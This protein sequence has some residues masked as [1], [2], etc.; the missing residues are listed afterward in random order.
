MAKIDRITDLTETEGQ[1]TAHAD[2]D[3][4]QED[5]E[6][7]LRAWASSSGVSI[8]TRAAPRSSLSTAAATALLTACGCACTAILATVG[9][10]TW[11]KISGLIVPAA[12]FFGLRL[13]SRESRS[14]LPRR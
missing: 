7:K 1:P 4:P 10:P 6:F 12:I 14:L 3:L 8:E 2:V 11:A 13:I 9:A 5:E